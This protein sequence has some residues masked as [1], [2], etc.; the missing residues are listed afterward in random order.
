MAG[1]YLAL[2]FRNIKKRGIRSWLTMLGIFIG[3]AAVVSLISMGSGLKEAITGQ[4]GEL[5]AD[6]LVVQNA[7]TGFGP[8]GSTA[9]EK[10]T[11]H[12][13][14]IVKR[15]PGVKMAVPRLIRAVSVS[16]NK[17]IGFEY[18]ADIPKETDEIEMV[19]S[20]LKI[21]LA[22]GRLLT[23]SDRNKVVIG[24]NIAVDEFD[25]EIK[26]GNKIT[27]QNESFEVVGVLKKA[28]SFIVNGIILMPHDDI[29]RTLD[30]GD[31]IDII[32]VQASDEDRVDSVA[33]GIEDAL[34]KDRKLKKGEEDFTVQT[35]QQ[36]LQAI[37]T[38]LAVINAV[39]VGIAAISLFVG[40]IG[41]TNTMYTSVVERTKEIGIM[42]SIGAR[43]RDILWIF[44]MESSLLGLVGGIV[45]AIIGLAM[46]YLIAFGVTTAFPGINFAITLSWSLIFGAITFALLV[47]TVSGLV[48]ALQASR[49]KPVEAL[50]A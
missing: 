37:N 27:I 28:S 22:Q 5:G 47:G 14:Q 10:L 45:G 15:I 26:V 31:E 44:L 4:F 6:K 9:V 33:R 46:A 40:G 3:I 7:E 39:V 42:K 49:M 25:K 41:I 23:K 2:A 50:R 43:N 17:E 48:P 13:L 16:Y 30:I 11:D 35:P 32:A 8:P 36:S 20:A 1:D 19:Y 38:I 18:A 24:N 12:D 21:E 34:R 29:V